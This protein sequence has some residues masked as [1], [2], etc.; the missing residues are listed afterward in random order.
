V[1]EGERRVGEVREHG[2][3]E[4]ARGRRPPSVSIRR[5]RSGVAVPRVSDV[6]VIVSRAVHGSG[7]PQP[8]PRRGNRLMGVGSPASRA[9]RTRVRR[10]VAYARSSRTPE[11]LPTGPD[12]Q[13]GN[14]LDSNPKRHS[15]LFRHYLPLDTSARWLASALSGSGNTS[16]SRTSSDPG[17]GFVRRAC[18]YS[19]ITFRASAL[20]RSM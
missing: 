9:A 17:D 18:M 10:P 12:R 16:A 8:D 11:D 4:V 20:P 13:A 6:V 7:G 1:G 19:S 14:A 15:S 2:R 5:C 3:I